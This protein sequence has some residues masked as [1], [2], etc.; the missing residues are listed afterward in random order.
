MNRTF[1]QETDEILSTDGLENVTEHYHLVRQLYL[2]SQETVRKV[3][4][5]KIEADLPAEDTWM[6]RQTVILTDKTWRGSSKK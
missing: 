6:K 2:E 5:L 4:Q 3:Q 1:N